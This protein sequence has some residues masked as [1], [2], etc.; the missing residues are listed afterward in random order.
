MKIVYKVLA[1]T[2]ML[3]SATATHA[4]DKNHYKKLYKQALSYGDV[5]TATSALN[6][7][8]VLGENSY[9][10]SLAIV[11]NRGGLYAQSYMVTKQL[12]ADKP[13]K[14]DLLALMLDNSS[15]L[16]LTKDALMYVDQ[17]LAQDKNNQFYLYQKGLL[18]YNTKDY[19]T[20]LQTINE[21]LSLP[22]NPT[23]QINADGIKEQQIAIPLQA[24]LYNLK[25]MVY[26]QL[27]DTA[28]ASMAFSKALELAPE[29]KMASINL[30]ALQNN[31]TK[32]EG[33]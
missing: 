8:I 2:L 22:A 7:L 32:Q 21:A 29:Y 27:K 19:S 12:L 1:I 23:D 6:Q 18:V 24:A 5:A 30:A 13:A 31:K 4:Q 28:G 14:K 17:L 10:D 20:C 25:G 26:Y 16:N 3:C 33:K 9:K 15:Q 11:Y